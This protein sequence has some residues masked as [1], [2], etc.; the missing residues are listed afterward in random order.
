LRSAL[1]GRAVGERRSAETRTEASGDRAEISSRLAASL[2]KNSTTLQEHQGTL[3]AART[4]LAALDRLEAGLRAAG[5][6]GEAGR[7]IRAAVEGT[8]FEGRNLLA[9]HVA[10]DGVENVEE[11][12]EAARG[13]FTGRVESAL[14]SLAGAEVERSN[15]VAAMEMGAVSG[16]AGAGTA[17]RS[18]A[19]RLGPEAAVRA[20]GNLNAAGVVRIL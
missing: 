19:D 4:A 10:A 14:R 6:N 12:I 17:L 1:S 2:R 9:D 20:H 7:I 15:L 11:G 3:G 16:A 8:V 18:A 5:S 13:Y